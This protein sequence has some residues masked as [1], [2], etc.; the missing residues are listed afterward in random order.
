MSN[1]FE[2]GTLLLEFTPWEMAKG[3]VEI[4]II[5]YVIYHLIIFLQRTRAVMILRGLGIFLVMLLL[6]Y[7]LRLE[8]IFFL[9][10]RL[11]MVIL[12]A[13]P[14]VFQPELR[15]ALEQ[16]GRR[17]FWVRSFAGLEKEDVI[18]L[19]HTLVT[20]VSDLAIV[21]MGAIVVIEQETPL[22]EYAASGTHVGGVVTPELLKTIFFP[23]TFLHDGAVIVRGDRVLAAGAFLPL[24]ENPE[25]S[26][27]IGSRHRSA[28]GI[29]E[30]TDSIALVVSEET[31]TI[32]LAHRGKLVRDVKPDALRELLLSICMP[33]ETSFSSF[34][35]VS[36]EKATSE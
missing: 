21:K 27:D 19:I 15:R 26:Q 18:K 22:D 3:I 16:I 35:G 13:L 33:Q 34:L 1:I 4:L 2:W 31:G 23:H 20:T 6:S 7:V 36:G 32:S 8:T 17:G 11:T 9:L 12:V 5:G 30:I 24:S 25:L 10:S 14:I 28:L 29:T